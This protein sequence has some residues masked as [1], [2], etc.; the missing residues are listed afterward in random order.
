M[1]I[2]FIGNRCNVLRVLLKH[3]T[4][5]IDIWSLRGSYLEKYLIRK[6]INHK[7]FT[8]N[9]KYKISSI[10][11]SNEFDVFISNGC[12]FVVPIV[13]KTMINIHPTYLPYL[14]G[15]KPLNGI[16]YNNMNFIG[17]TMHHITDEI[18]GGNVIYRKKH[19]I[20]NDID[21]GLIYFLSFY[22]EGIVMKKGWKILLNNKFNYFG[23]PIDVSKGTYFNRTID[24]TIV[25]FQIMGVKDVIRIVK[26]FG[27]ESQGATVK[28]VSG[29][30]KINKIFEASEITDELLVS[31]YK[32]YSPGHI[33]LKYDNK[34]LIK[35]LDGIVKISNYC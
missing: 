20:S 10:I 22:L 11:L 4:Y 23:K 21:Q 26:S 35:T 32:D 24:K 3:Y 1:K 29:D 6:E 34:I 8:E 18:D 14:R 31:I 33:L 12:P 19:D 30:Y 5:D 25:N 2:L 27:V 15:K 16:Y 7:T 17:A 13:D 9:D 28:G